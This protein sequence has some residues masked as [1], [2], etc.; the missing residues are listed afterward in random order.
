ML[1]GSYRDSSIG[2]MDAEALR[3]VHTEAAIP[4]G[5]ARLLAVVSWRARLD[6][7][8]CRGG[9]VSHEIPDK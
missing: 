3:F 9:A 2:T 4:A 7:I 1:S 6:M 5:P 8:G